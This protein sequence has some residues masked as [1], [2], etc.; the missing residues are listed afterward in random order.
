[1]AH[2][3]ALRHGVTVGRR[4]RPPPSQPAGAP[5]LPHPLGL[6]DAMAHPAPRSLPTPA[7]TG[8]SVVSG[9]PSAESAGSPPLAE[10]T[11]R[12]TPTARPRLAVGYVCVSDD[13]DL[14]NG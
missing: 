9:I 8:S 11:R 7:L 12:A 1:M 13:E 2:G 5:R 10:P 14:V 3:H 4:L 6:E